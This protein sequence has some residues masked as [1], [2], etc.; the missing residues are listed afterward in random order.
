[1]HGVFA[2]GALRVVGH[3]IQLADERSYRGT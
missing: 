1:L 2:I 3:I